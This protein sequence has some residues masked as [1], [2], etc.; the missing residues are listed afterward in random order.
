MTQE[1]KKV[2]AWYNKT[3]KTNIAE[4]GWKNY[5]VWSRISTYQTLS[6]PFIAANKDRVD[7]LYISTY[8]TLSEPFIA[9]HKDLVDWP[10]ISQFQ[11]LSE[12]FIAAHKDLVSWSLIS[13][14]QTLSEPFIADHKGLVD[15][16]HISKYQTLS[17]PFIAANKDRVDWLYISTYQTLSEPFIAN[18]KDLVDWPCISQ[19]QT[20]SEPFIA[21]H[22]D[23]VDWPCISLHQILSKSFFKK[24]SDQLGCTFD[25]VDDTTWLYASEKRKIDHI[26]KNAPEFKVKR[27]EGGRY[28]LAY[29]ATHSNGRSNYDR[30]IRYEVGKTYEALCDHDMQENNSFGLSAWTKEGAKNFLPNGELYLV[31]I[32]ISD[33]GAMVHDGKKIRCKKQTFVKR[34]DTNLFK[35]IMNGVSKHFG[36]SDRPTTA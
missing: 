22:K 24:Y 26:R 6:E 17:E 10:C 8:Q 29:K 28:I 27:D 21:D 31:K 18:H 33:I 1:E 36:N 34:I 32:Y 12:P 4:E 25:Q 19:F 35:R 13:Q 11:T 30:R 15:W 7:W 5:V 23:R 20:L 9:N 16:L 2:L 14:F 3:Y